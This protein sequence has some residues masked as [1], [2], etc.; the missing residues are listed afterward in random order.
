MMGDM[1]KKRNGGKIA[2]CVVVILALL[3][4]AGVGTY[5]YF[6]GEL[7]FLSSKETFSTRYIAADGTQLNV[8]DEEGNQAT[9]T[10][11][12]EVQ[13]S[14]KTKKFDDTEYTKVTANNA[15]Y[16]VKQSDLVDDK[17]NTVLE[18]ELWAYRTATVY[19]DDSSNKINGLI[20][21]GTK[22]EVTGHSEVKDDGTVERYGYD[23][24]FVYAKYL[25]N[26]E[27]KATSDNDSDI[28]KT[29]LAN[30]EDEYGAG[31]VSALDYY[32]N[33]KPKFENNTMP[34][35]ARTLYISA[36]TVGNIDAYIDLAKQTKVN[37]F[38]ID[39]RDSHVIT[40]QSDTM[41]EW[42]PS[43]YNAAAFTKDD[44]K[45]LVQKAKD[46]GIY[47]IARI[48]AFKDVHFMEDHPEYA[49]KDKSTGQPFDYADAYWPSAFVRKVWEYNVDLAKEVVTDLGFNEV[50]FD[51]VRFPEEIDYYADIKGTVDLQNQYNE[52]RAQAVQRFLM[53]ACDEIHKVNGYVSAD[54][55]GETSNNYVAAYGQ[56][57]PA[58]SGVVDAISAMPYPDHFKEHDY[59]ITETVWTVPYKLFKAWGDDVKKMQDMT[60][61]P[62]RIRTWL[63]GYDSI[64]EPYVEYDN[65]KIHDQIQGLRDSGIYD[66]G[67]IIWNSSSSLDKYTSYKD[68]L[69]EE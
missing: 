2:V 17:N 69:S 25:T 35:V 23:G 51:Y 52:T 8:L 58:I 63:Q 42:S 48:T 26:D 18:K 55:F 3:A 30:T 6:G 38:V 44:F 10:R 37:A 41:K 28:A 60:P 66:N 21:K 59:G 27:N 4:A 65:S 29:M 19:A 20:T 62:A 24:G 15:T 14:N 12:T 45:A 1:Q 13:A 50:Q 68:A 39:I 64:R 5:A 31:P 7:P 43:S 34:D 49:I 47:L 46:A 56:Y 33:E 40:Y 9:L 53:Y 16:Y 61:S 54:V 67:Y 32:E 36:G 11:G 22:I 57:W